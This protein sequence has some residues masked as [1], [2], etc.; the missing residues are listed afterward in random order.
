MYLCVYITSWEERVD[1]SV[2]CLAGDDFGLD[3]IIF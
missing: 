2:N 3:V 1:I